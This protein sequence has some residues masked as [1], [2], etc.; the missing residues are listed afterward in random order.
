[1]DRTPQ[2]SA[3]SACASQARRNQQPNH[4]RSQ[5]NKKIAPAM[6][7]FIGRMHF[8]HWSIVSC[9]PVPPDSISAVPPSLPNPPRELT[10]T[11]RIV[12]S[13]GAIHSPIVNRGA[14]KSAS[15]PQPSPATALVFAFAV[16]NSRRHSDPERSRRGRIPK[17]SP[18]QSLWP[19]FVE[20]LQAQFGRTV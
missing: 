1:M 20:T 4:D 10:L 12:I 19:F 3:P 8:E 17:N 2:S 9:R 14:E 6:Y 15:L 7:R 16:L 18:P 13:T 11:Q 5:M